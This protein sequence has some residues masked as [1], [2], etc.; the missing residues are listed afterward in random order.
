[1]REKFG[2]SLRLVERWSS[3]HAWVLRTRLWD[4]H[5]DRISVAVSTDTIQTMRLEH[6]EWD[7]SVSAAAGETLEAR[8]RAWRD[9]SLRRARWPHTRRTPARARPTPFQ[10]RRA[11]VASLCGAR[12]DTCK[13]RAAAARG[14]RAA[15]DDAAPT[16]RVIGLGS[17]QIQRRFTAAARAAGIEARLTA[18]SGRVGLA[19]EL[20]ARG[21]ST[22]ER[23]AV[24]KYL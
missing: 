23:G 3:V 11:A 13:A 19:S 8:M 4:E 7:H 16:D 5:Q 20:T 17:L 21:A 22:T 18:H 6:A 14:S 2:I 15:D 24:A 9:D 12:T 1:M 10:P